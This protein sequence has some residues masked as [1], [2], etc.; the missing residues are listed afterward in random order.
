MND[1]GDQSEVAQIYQPELVAEKVGEGEVEEEAEVELDIEGSE[2]FPEELGVFDVDDV[3]TAPHQEEHLHVKNYEKYDV[4]EGGQDE[5]EV[6][7]LSLVSLTYEPMM[8]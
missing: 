1:L 3:V 6:A 4:G 2:F 5:V 8:Y 7:A